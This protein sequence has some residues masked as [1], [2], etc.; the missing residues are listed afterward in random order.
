MRA[1]TCTMRA[2]RGYAVMACGTF[3]GGAFGIGNALRLAWG[4]SSITRALQH[5]SRRN[6]RRTRTCWQAA[7]GCRPR[8][9][10][11]HGSRPQR[12]A[13]ATAAGP[14]RRRRPRCATGQPRARRRLSAHAW[15][16]RRNRSGAVSHR[17]AWRNYA[18]AGGSQALHTPP[19]TGCAG[20]CCAH[21][22]GQ[23][24]H[25]FTSTMHALRHSKTWNTPCAASWFSICCKVVLLQGTGGHAHPPYA[26][27]CGPSPAP[28]EAPASHDAH[29][30]TCRTRPPH[31][32]AQTR[33]QP[34]ASCRTDAAERGVPRRCRGAAADQVAV[35]PRHC[36]QRSVWCTAVV[37]RQGRR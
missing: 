32:H 30:H 23:T 12:T 6:P 31:M 37:R 29:T 7:A 11:R 27:P 36:C 25:A 5:T 17:C 34:M 14:W 24:C 2:A 16:G 26:T 20:L 18:G 33:A 35:G 9:A 22:L 15:R 21:A 10:W 4:K 3:G 13:V 19:R 28:P 1:G 8:R